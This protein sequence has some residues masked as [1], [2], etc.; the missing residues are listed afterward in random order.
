M[1]SRIIHPVMTSKEKIYAQILE[2]RNAI[3]KLNGNAPR[4]DIDKCLHTNYAQTHTRAELN[5]ELGIAQSCLRNARSKK[6]IEKWYG[7]PAGIAYREEHEAKIKS[8]RREV[9]NTHRDT[10]SD[11]HRFIYQHLGKQW[12]VR[13]IGERAM[14]IEL[15][16]KDGKSQF[17]YDIELYYGHET[18]DP[19]KFEISCSS[20]GGYD[21]TQDSRRLDYF[22]GLT[23]LSKYDV[24]T[25]LKS[26]LKSF[27]DY[28]YRQGNEIYRLENELENPPY[29]G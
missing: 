17:G 8:L 6:A 21:P 18:C 4:Y 10:T 15:L 24:A 16:D 23:T 27:S 11:V 5:A 20:V 26:L 22:I 19:D 29:N 3:D 14:T 2:T 7:T 1:A 9:L 13:V 28:C 25:E 12:R